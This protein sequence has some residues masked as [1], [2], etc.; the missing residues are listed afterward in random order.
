LVHKIEDAKNKAQQRLVQVDDQIHPI[1]KW[2][3]NFL[4]QLAFMARIKEGHNGS[5]EVLKLIKKVINMKM[6]YL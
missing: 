1:I 5:D 6:P 4:Q 3:E 2:L